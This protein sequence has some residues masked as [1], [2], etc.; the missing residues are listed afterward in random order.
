[1]PKNGVGW[2]SLTLIAQ[3]ILIAQNYLFTQT[4]FLIFEMI[5]VS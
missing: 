3:K 1:M 2:R 4:M 5:A